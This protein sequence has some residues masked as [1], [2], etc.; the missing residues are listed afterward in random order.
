MGFFDNPMMMGGSS[1]LGNFLEQLI[2]RPIIEGA[3]RRNLARADE[4]VGY[5]R[6]E[7]GRIPDIAQS[8]GLR[9]LQG[10]DFESMFRP[11]GPSGYST[12]RGFD[13][14][15]VQPQDINERAYAYNPAYLRSAAQEI[16]RGLNQAQVAPGSLFGQ[17]DLPDFE[18]GARLTDRLEGLA[19]G[20]AQQQAIASQSAIGRGLGGGMDLQELTSGPLANIGLQTDIGRMRGAQQI[21]SDLEGQEQAYNLQRGGIQAGLASQEA[22]INAA[23]TQAAAQASSQMIGTGESLAAG[24]LAARLQ[25]RLGEAG[26]SQQ[27]QSENVS[28]ALQLALAR[29]GMAESGLDRRFNTETQRFNAQ[30]GVSQ[31]IMSALMGESGLRMGG[32]RDMASILA[33]VQEMLPLWNLGINDS[34]GMAMQAQAL[35]DARNQ[36]NQSHGG[37]SFLGSGYSW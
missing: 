29:A 24:N 11:R 7:A 27:A 17:V 22:Q 19:E 37:L 30:R 28:R 16:A 33:G 5:V 12:L 10:M 13:L 6:D 18:G 35:R 21:K 36:A 14:E 3:N 9:G 4:A 1:F 31:D 2:N 23:L 8:S 25:A 15:D 34:M 26:L 32:A 20:S